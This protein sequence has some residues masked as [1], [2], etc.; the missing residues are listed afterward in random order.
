LASGLFSTYTERRN[1]NRFCLLLFRQEI[2]PRTKLRNIAPIIHSAALFSS[3]SLPLPLLLFLS[4][5]SF[6]SF[7][8]ISFLL[9]FPSFYSIVFFF[10]TLVLRARLSLLVPKYFHQ[11]DGH[12]GKRNY[13]CM[14]LLSFHR[15]CVYVHTIH[16]TVSMTFARACNFRE[17][18]DTIRHHSR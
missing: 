6:L 10:C 16:N 1:R 5:P 7:I 14:Y 11:G 15:S 13:R 4:F 8:F 18:I 17:I 12:A 9:F 2:I 3:P